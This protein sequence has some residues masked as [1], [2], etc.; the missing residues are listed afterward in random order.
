[1]DE[2]QQQQNCVDDGRNYTF[3]D[4]KLMHINAEQLLDWNAPIDTI[5]AYESYNLTTKSFDNEIYC[6]CSDPLSFG[7]RREY[8]FLADETVLETIVKHQ[9]SSHAAKQ[10]VVNIET[11]SMDDI[12]CYTGLSCNSSLC[13]DWRQVCN[14]IIDCQDGEDEGEK[15]LQLE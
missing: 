7:T 11:M 5:S 8:R 9:I 3:R 10:S 4:L 13:L 15:C 12:T 1:M 14:G 2:I 6:N